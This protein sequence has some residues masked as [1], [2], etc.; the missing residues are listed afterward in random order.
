ML[1]AADTDD[2]ILNAAQQLQAIVETRIKD[3]FGDVAYGRAVEE[4]GVLREEMIEFEEPGIYNDIVRDLKKKLLGSE[5]GGDRREMWWEVRKA[6]L[7]LVKNRDSLQSKVGEEEAEQVSNKFHSRRIT[8]L[9]HNLV[10]PIQVKAKAS[11]LPRKTSDGRFC[12]T[13][14]MAANLTHPFS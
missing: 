4:L 12:K 7:G 13:W 3:S 1:E 11:P 14:E 5:L 10:P 2:T 8:R 9:K 6:R